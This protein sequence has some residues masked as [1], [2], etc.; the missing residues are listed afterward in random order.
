M[1]NAHQPQ[2]AAVR[3]G[4]L[5]SQ[6]PAVNHTFILREIRILRQCG[7]DIR[8]VSIRQPDRRPDV[9]SPEEADEYRFTSFV[10][11]AGIFRIAAGHARAFFARPFRYLSTLAFAIGLAGWNLR[12]A[13]RH[14]IYFAEAVIAGDQLS[15]QGVQHAHTHFSS[16]VMLL[17]SRLFPITF[18][19]TIHGP[20]EFDDVVGFHLAEKVAA[21]RFVAAISR[22][23]SS[24]LMRASD[25][26]HWEKIRT[27]PLGVDPEAFLPRPAPSGFEVLCVGRLAPVKAHIV[28][29]GA[30]GRLVRAGRTGVRLL[31]IG[32]GPS[33][34]AI[35][36]EVAR[37]GLET[38]VSVVGALNHD[39]VLDYYR[40]ASVFTLASFAEGVPVVL[41]EAMAMEI[42]C[43]ATWVAGV[44]ELIRDKIDGLLV[45]PSHEEA[46]ASAIAILMDD[47]ELRI[48]LGCAA[49]QRVIQCYNL[50]RNVGRLAE[51]FRETLGGRRPTRDLN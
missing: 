42:P 8:V 14:I 25:P 28:L 32:D 46:L 45:P 50:S 13:A 40:R 26:A 11:G 27:L 16:T 2:G 35:E 44:P 20:E 48:R 9:L 4:Y 34:P 1:E 33:R 23:A 29:I 30:I 12:A 39:Q 10:L 6:Y 24:Q 41:M 37:R 47:K 36:K 19:M 5:I 43:V 15:S 38:C 51:A 21:A 3:L 22:F 17:V 31:L 7:F 18:S 49:R